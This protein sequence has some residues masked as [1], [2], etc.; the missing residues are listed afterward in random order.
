[1]Q[2]HSTKFRLVAVIG[3]TAVAVLGVSCEAE[4]EARLPAQIGVSRHAARS[5]ALHVERLWPPRRDPVRLTVWE[6]CRQ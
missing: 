1:M 3:A 5:R 6:I 4:A 2:G